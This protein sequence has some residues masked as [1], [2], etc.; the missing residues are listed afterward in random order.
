MIIHKQDV[1]N[2]E[3]ILKFLQD[4]ILSEDLAEKY[5]ELELEWL[6]LSVSQFEMFKERVR[7]EYLNT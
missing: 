4:Y 6:K 5:T 7:E 3:D 1:T 2:L